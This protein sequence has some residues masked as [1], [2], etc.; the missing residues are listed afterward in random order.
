[1]LLSLKVVCL[2]LLLLVGFVKPQIS[3]QTSRGE[4]I[5]FHANYGS[6]K[7]QLWYGEADVFLGIPYVQAP[8]GNLR[9]AKPVP[10][11]KF[12]TTPLNASRMGPAC[13]QTY[14]LRGLSMSEDCLY[15][16][17]FTP[18]AAST[19]KYSV[20]VF[21][22]GGAFT[23][24]HAADF[25]TPGI[26][27]NLVSRDVV[28]VTIQYRLG[29]L[30]FFTTHSD[31][32][33]PNLGMLDQ[34]EALKW[35]QSEIANFGGDPYR[36]TLFGQSA[37]SASTSAHIFSPTSQN[38]FQQAIME[39]G[40]I[41][42]SFEGS[43][44]LTNLSESRAY[45]LCNFTQ[46]QWKAR[47]FTLLQNCLKTMDYQKFLDAENFNVH[48]WQIVQDN[49]FMPD[50]PRKLYQNRPNI[51]V[52]YGNNK[53]EWSLVDLQLLAS[54]S[55]PLSTYTRQY[56]EFIFQVYAYY[57]A[58]RE[59]DVQ[60]I[61]EGVYVPP[62]TAD[63]DN[64]AWLKIINNMFSGISF[65]SFVGREIEWFVFNQ[66]SQVYT[67]E[68]LFPTQV[69]RPTT[70]PGWEPIFHCAELYLLFMP[71]FYWQP[72]YDNGT[73]S[74]DE[75]KVADWLG[76]T[77]T[78]FA[79]YGKPTLDNSWKPTTSIGITEQEY[80]QINVETQMAKGFRST[81]QLLWNKALPAIIGTWPPEM[82]DYNNGSVVEF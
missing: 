10:L 31:D 28:I 67:Y 74:P 75:F 29:L 72:L 36:I 3:V 1:M 8:I 20:M 33:P 73:L 49:Y 48:G 12:P 38:M 78:N 52:I 22:H 77:W 24:G 43:M 2:G 51:P 42:T 37:G 32:F 44:G 13:P 65:T 19:Y 80:L 50:V 41:L 47:Q 34:N 62:G 6:D 11:T 63:D 60:G 57:L 59:L 39:S 53:D 58:E 76:M 45:T 7:S 21:I 35:I 26:V 79:K 54:G 64:V 5:G 82:P 56:V 18:H 14:N 81:D 61:L 46:E 16:N 70:V 71:D 15:L 68:F 17:I 40:S 25:P 4:V 55:N 27:R 23:T 69:G 66:N 30:G 9:F